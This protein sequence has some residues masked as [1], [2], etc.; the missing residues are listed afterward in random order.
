M[1]LMQ[2]KEAVCEVG[3]L[4]YE[5]G[6][7]VAGDGNVSVRLDDGNILVTPAGLCKGRLEAQDLVLCSPDGSLLDAAEDKR[8]SSELAMHLRVYQERLDVHA[9]VHAHPP[10]ATAF[11]VCRMPLED[12]YLPEVAAF[13]GRVEVCNFAL[14]GTAAVG[15]SIVPYLA[16]SNAV[17]LANHGALTWAGDIMRAFDYME[18]VEHV[19]KIHAQIA[20]LGGGVT[21]DAETLDALRAKREHPSLDEAILDHN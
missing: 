17:L 10:F 2:A 4:L 8:P 12:V 3:R 21:L 15:E 9:V 16:S 11:A 1:N 19:A 5:R 14:P 18:S 6:L 20:A 13:L 7:L